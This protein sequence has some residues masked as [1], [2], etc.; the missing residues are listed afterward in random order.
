MRLHRRWGPYW[1]STCY[2]WSCRI[3]RSISIRRN[4]IPIL[5]WFL[6]VSSNN[7][8]CFRKCVALIAES[9]L[10]VTS[11][12]T[13]I[14]YSRNSFIRGPLSSPRHLWRLRRQFHH[15][16]RDFEWSG[17]RR[18]LWENFSVSRLKQPEDSLFDNVGLW[19]SIDTLE[20]T[21]F[22]RTADDIWLHFAWQNH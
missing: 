22:S 10:V 2:C 21:P 4:I 20:M 19:G 13:T 3:I 1:H 14:N 11:S 8:V 9:V 17:Q 16:E 5:M 6:E 15:Y 18:R 12:P 7:A